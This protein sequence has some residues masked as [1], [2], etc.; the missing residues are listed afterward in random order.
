M[1]DEVNTEDGKEEGRVFSRFDYNARVPSFM[2]D[3]AWTARKLIEDGRKLD[4]LLLLAVSVDGFVSIWFH[5]D[6][7]AA[8]ELLQRCGPK[9]KEVPGTLRFTE[10]LRR[11]APT[12][13]FRDRIAVP[14][15]VADW[16]RH[17]PR[18]ATAKL[19]AEYRDAC[20]R[21]GPADDPALDAFLQLFS[22]V[23]E[24]TEL[25]RMAD[26]YTYAALAYRFVRNPL[27]HHGYA[28][29]QAPTVADGHEVV[30]VDQFDGALG[31]SIGP[32]IYVDWLYQAAD[33]YYGFAMD[34][35]LWSAMGYE[36]GA[37]PQRVLDSAWQHALR[38]RS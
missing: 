28:A 27:V 8:A 12:D 25:R 5:D 9:V 33:S 32:S 2:S 29:W 36:P 15:F 21:F 38:S 34:R 20:G 1:S 3:R 7:D 18:N 10:F 30:Y 17:E 26:E 31:L 6:P 16:L 35:P 11:F 37:R 19:I 23:R 13:R 4:A 24:R 14:L 22:E